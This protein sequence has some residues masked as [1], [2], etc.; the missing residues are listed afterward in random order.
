MLEA[1]VVVLMPSAALFVCG[2]TVIVIT[3]ESKPF[4]LV[5]R[6]GRRHGAVFSRIGNPVFWVVLKQHVRSADIPC[7]PPG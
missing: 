2:N 4:L 5:L 1:P 6:T 7:A 3:A